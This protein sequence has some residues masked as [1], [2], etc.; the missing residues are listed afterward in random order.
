MR[1]RTMLTCGLLVF[2]LSLGTVSWPILEHPQETS[3]YKP[4]TYFAA[5]AWCNPA[6]TIAWNCGPKCDARPGF[7]PVASGGDGSSTQ[8]WYVG[9]DTS[10][11]QVIV[12]YE[13]TDVN[14]M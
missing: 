9:Y 2:A 12:A 14:N 4:Y 3:S 5:V 6:Q 13:G 1:P 7:V 8:F 11:S 10:L